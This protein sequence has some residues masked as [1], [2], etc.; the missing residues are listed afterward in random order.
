MVTAEWVLLISG[1]ATMHQKCI[2]VTVNLI[3]HESG[4]GDRW[5]QYIGLITLKQPNTVS[6]VQ[7]IFLAP[8]FE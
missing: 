1:I 7:T 6:T 5:K 3:E 8:S 4:L 2:I